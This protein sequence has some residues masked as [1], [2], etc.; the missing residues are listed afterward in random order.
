MKNKMTKYLFLLLPIS[1]LAFFGLKSFSHSSDNQMVAYKFSA[2]DLQPTATQKKVESMVAEILSSYHFRKV[3]LNDSLSSKILDNY[4][5]ELDFNKMNFTAKDVEGFDKFRFELDDQL[6]AGDLTAAYQIY[7]VYRKRAKE[8]FTFVTSLLNKPMDFKT[9]EIYTPDREKASWAKSSSDLDDIWRK[10]VK[11][12][13][14]DWKISGK[15]DSVSVKDLTERYKRSEKYFDK[16]KSEDVFQQFMNSFT[17]SVDP[18][19]TYFIPKTAS[20]FNQEMSQSFEG[21]G[22]TLRNE[23]D[24]VQIVDLIVGGPAFRSKQL[25]PKDRIV[26]VAQGDDKP[27]QDIVGWFTDDAVKLIKGPKNTIVRL[28]ILSGDASIGSVPKEIRLVREKIKLEEGTAKKEILNFSRDGKDYKYGL[29]TI[30]LFYRDFEGAKSGEQGFKSTT[31]DVKRYLTE[32]KADKVDGVIVDL[33]NNGGGS[34]TEAVNLTGLFI[35]QGPVVQRKQSDGEITAEYD[36][37]PSVTY[38]GPVSVLVNRFSASAS[39]IFAGAIQDYKRGL[40]IGEQTYGKGTVQSL[41]DLERFLKGE[42][43]GVG[44]LKI[45]MEKFYRITGSSTQHKGVTPDIEL[46]STF[47]ASEFGESSQ[48]SA[49]PWDMIASTKYTPSNNVT[50]KE[51]AFLRGKYQGRLKT[52]TDLKK[53]LTE[54]ENYKKAKEKKSISLQ[55]DKRRKE[56]DEQKKKNIVEPTDELA[57]NEL[58]PAGTKPVV[59]KEKVA[60]DSTSIAVAKVKAL[61]E[62]HEKDT[63]LKETERILTDFISNTPTNGVKVSQV[64]NKK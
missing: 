51:V 64:E 7:N 45:T 57:G 29:I 49:L 30:P 21:I 12:T 5:K 43:E 27:Y 1:L 20:T 54:I 55:E 44:Q 62:K 25:N 22:A 60:T 56:I 8:R 17:E 36:R 32:L 53:L 61:K 42:P 26:A 50:E 31:A 59:P 23:G 33:R 37:D 18:H 24:Y 2:D 15:A 38:D 14:L 46:P 28:K 10:A 34:L 4:I 40:I 58:L 52:E 39:E 13:L 48:P 9:D 11:S 35:P 16:T 41:I 63:F 6:K 3:P 47:S 19:T